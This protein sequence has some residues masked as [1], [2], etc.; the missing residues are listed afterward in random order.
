MGYMK[1]VACRKCNYENP[2]D[3]TYCCH[4]GSEF[5]PFNHSFWKRH[6]C[7]LLITL[8]IFIFILLPLFSIVAL[9]KS[10]SADSA[11]DTPTN[12][13]VQGSEDKIALITLDGVIVDS[14]IGGFGPPTGII[15]EKKLRKTL[16]KIENDSHVKGILLKVNSPGGSAAASHEIYRDFLS[17][18]KRTGKKIIT[19]FSDIAASGGYYISMASDYI[20]S[21]PSTITGSIGV[22]LTTFNF[23]DVAGKYGVKNIVYKSGPYKDI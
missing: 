20:V 8:F 9:I 12:V 14:D 7:F 11:K 3:A 23:S 15:S 16:Q 1:T 5:Y 21:N 10:I 17:F 4:C 22:I 2:R 6:K 19:Y 18:K 13:V